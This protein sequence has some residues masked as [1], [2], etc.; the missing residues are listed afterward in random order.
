MLD[1]SERVTGEAA[2]GMDWALDKALESQA[3]WFVW[4]CDG[5]GVSL[6]RQVDSA[7]A[8]KNGIDYF[9]FKGSEAVEEPEQPY[10]EGGKTKNKTNRETFYN[11]RA[12]YWWRLRDRCYNTYSAVERGEYVDPE[13]QMSLSTS[14]SNLDQIRSEH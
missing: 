5:L 9:M 8:D 1:S 10:T 3:D 13:D 12:Q 14:I 2:D 4:D 7:L 6:K 11:K